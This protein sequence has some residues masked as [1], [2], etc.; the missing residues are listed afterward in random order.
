MRWWL[1]SEAEGAVTGAEKS[2]NRRIK[3]VFHRIEI[4]GVSVGVL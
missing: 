3:H 4:L 1:I 2:A